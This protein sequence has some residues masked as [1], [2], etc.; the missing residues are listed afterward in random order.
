MTLDEKEGCPAKQVRSAQEVVGYW[1]RKGSF[2]AS[3]CFILAEAV[4]EGSMSPTGP[5]PGLKAACRDD[6][7]MEHHH[8]SALPKT[9]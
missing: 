8:F 2:M 3:N 9:V 4:L 7:A 6:L 1:E 5:Y